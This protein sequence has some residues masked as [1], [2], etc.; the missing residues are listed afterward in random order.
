MKH[1]AIIAL[2]AITLVGCF[3][4]KKKSSTTPPS[5][6][7]T[8]A[9]VERAAAKFPGSTLATLTEGKTIYEAH[10]GSCHALKSPTSE[11]ENEWRKIVPNMVQKVNKKEGK[12]L[13]QAS[14][15]KIL[16]YLVTMAQAH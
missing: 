1:L 8:Q 15:D 2:A 13:G 4:S 6:G 5:T 3:T 14:E 9:D 16:A 10:C 12:P 11:S 7:I